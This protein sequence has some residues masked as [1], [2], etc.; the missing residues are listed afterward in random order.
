MVFNDLKIYAIV[1]VFFVFFHGNV[2]IFCSFLES[3][4]LI[5]AV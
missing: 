1:F 4:E 5:D 3:D 2:A